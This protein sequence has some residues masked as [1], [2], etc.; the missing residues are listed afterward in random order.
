MDYADTSAV[1]SPVFPQD[2]QDNIRVAAFDADDTLWDCQSYFDDMEE[3]YCRFLHRWGDAEHI[4]ASLYEVERGNMAELGYGSKAVIIS[5]VENAIRVSNGQISAEDIGTIVA[6]GR[7]L[8]RLP[9][10]PL[11]GV[12]ETLAW[13]RSL[14][15]F[16]MVLFTKGDHIEQEQKLERSG[17]RG[18]FDDV[19]IVAD[20]HEGE[21]RRLC[22][23]HN[24]D[25]HE[26]VMVGNSFKSD[27]APAIAIGA[28]GI[29]IPYHV[30]W[31][32]EHAE[33][34][35]HPDIVTLTRFE[36]LKEVLKEER[37]KRKEE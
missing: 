11:P 18:F 17:L 30:M 33:P 3:W 26:L 36:E 20:K 27:I 4:S 23:R 15:R 6:K 14:S 19:V 29:H 28:K 5:L 24:V 13:L 7:T 32:Y 9:A 12:R 2:W 8:L 31:R 35:A 37:G 21:Y 10:T 16:R 34:F 22:E 1:L 25:A